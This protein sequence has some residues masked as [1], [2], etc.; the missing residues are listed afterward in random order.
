MPMKNGGPTAFECGGIDKGSTAHDCGD[1]ALPRVHRSLH[2][3]GILL[4]SG[5][6]NHHR[7]SVQGHDRQTSRRRLEREVK[8]VMIMIV[9]YYWRYHGG[10]GVCKNCRK[11]ATYA[12]QRIRRCP[13]GENKPPCGKCEI[14]CLKPLMSSQIRDVMRFAWPKMLYR[15]PNPGHPAPSCSTKDPSRHLMGY[16]SLPRSRASSERA[17]FLL[18]TRHTHR[19]GSENAGN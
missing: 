8:T 11:L 16:G 19:I 3:E 17:H 1:Q 18:L 9:M 12:E 2:G 10:K 13:F 6:E 15:H 4:I 14:R 5:N 7:L